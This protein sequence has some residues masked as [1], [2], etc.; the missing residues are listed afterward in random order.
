VIR[1]LA[2]SPTLRVIGKRLLQSIPVLWGVTFVTFALLNL[3]P[4][5]AASSL[6]GEGATPASL[7]ALTLKLGLNQPFFV[8]YGHWIAGAIHGQ[9][10]HSLTTGQSV[11]TI[12]G[13]RLPISLELV[14]FAFVLS[15]L[16]SV[17][18][19][20]LAAS[21]PSGIFDRISIA[22]SMAGLSIPN[23]V[24]GL[25]LILIFAVHLGV[26]PAIGFV[27]ISDGLW[28]NIRTILLPSTTI[29]LVLISSYSRVLRADLLEQ[30]SSEDY[31]VT[32]RAKGVP[33][34]LILLRH[35]LR[36]SLFGL[37]TLIGLNLGT[38]IGGTVIV[39][40][41]FAIPGIGQELLL[42]IGLK[43]VV[44]VEA[45]VTLL[46][47]TVVLSN[48]AADLLYAFLDPRIRYDTR[49]S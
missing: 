1:S 27:P 48:L 28:Q 21:K 19:A 46:A 25:L 41:I 43:D 38:L 22:L 35:A 26:L 31:I 11:S 12:L 44:V 2:Q 17:P 42:S 3:L 34:W 20:L 4:G 29:A 5:T 9:F 49:S 39:E 47:V 16:V 30:L 15:I 7:R 13:Q 40:Q 14:G 37:I 6:L 8:R 45:I 18:L 36:N 24:V 33:P 32:A 10:G 23:F